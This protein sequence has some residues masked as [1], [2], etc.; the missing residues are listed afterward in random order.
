MSC[1][2]CNVSLTK[3]EFEYSIS[4]YSLPLCRECQEKYGPLKNKFEKQKSRSTPEAIKLYEILVKLGVKAKLEQWDK[5]KHIDIAIPDARINLEID[6]MQHVYNE[7]QALADLKRTYYSFKKNYVT[8][9]I[10]NK[11]IQEKAYETAK[12]L[13]ML[14][15]EQ[16]SD[17]E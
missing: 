11:L 17:D 1:S 2:K 13:K 15:E 12:Y 14:I 7:K 3:K 4:K 6:G 9:H 10:P 16:I 5:H 8:L